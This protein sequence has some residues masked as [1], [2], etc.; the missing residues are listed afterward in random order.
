M[1][2]EIRVKATKSDNRGKSNSK[3][4]RLH[5]V[6]GREREQAEGEAGGGPHNVGSQK[7]F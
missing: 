7:Y 1:Q 5:T 4:S 3:P 2:R 6:T